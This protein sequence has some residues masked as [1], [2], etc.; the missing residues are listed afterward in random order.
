MPESFTTSVLV[1]DHNPILLEGISSLI[2]TEPDMVL[3]GA[4]SDLQTGLILVAGASLDCV[5]IDLDV[6][7]AAGPD[8]IRNLRKGDVSLAIIG[9]ITYELD[10]RVSEALNSGASTILGKDQISQSLIE[11][12]RKTRRGS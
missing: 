6:P 11:L 7:S 8:G 9:L 5:L 2:R 12:I 3:A 10:D 1:I 4:A